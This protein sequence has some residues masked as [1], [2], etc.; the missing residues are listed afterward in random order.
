MGQGGW[1]I[2][3]R[4]GLSNIAIRRVTGIIGL[5]KSERNYQSWKRSRKLLQVERSTGINA[6]SKR[7]HELSEFERDK[8]SEFER[9]AS[10][11]SAQRAQE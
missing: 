4:T 10:Y 8:L 7:A 6:S 2:G 9:N 3:V 11:P 5:R 1:I